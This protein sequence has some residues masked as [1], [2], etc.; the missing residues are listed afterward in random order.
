M[1]LLQSRELSLPTEHVTEVLKLFAMPKRQIEIRY[2]DG[3]IETETETD[4]EIE[5]EEIVLYL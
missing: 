3:E 2:R 4:T 1:V 5:I